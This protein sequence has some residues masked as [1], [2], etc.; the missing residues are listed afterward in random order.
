MPPPSGARD[1]CRMGPPTMP[2][3][4]AIMPS[5]PGGKG[6]RRHFRHWTPFPPRSSRLHGQATTSARR[7]FSPISSGQLTLWTVPAAQLPALGDL[8]S[9]ASLPGS[10]RGSSLAGLQPPS[11]TLPARPSHRWTPRSRAPASSPSGAVAEE[12]GRG[13]MASLAARVR[14]ALLQAKRIPDDEEHAEYEEQIKRAQAEGLAK[15]RALEGPCQVLHLHHR[16]RLRAC[17]HRQ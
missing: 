1:R 5:V 8:L 2:T 13:A 9:P 4:D 3:S 15:G 6:G 17:F 10:L 7:T 11:L 12:I 14:E 16:C